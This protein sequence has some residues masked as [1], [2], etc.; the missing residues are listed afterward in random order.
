MTPESIRQE[1]ESIRAIAGDSE[2]AHVAE[3]S[4]RHRVLL[5]IADG[6]ATDPAACAREVLKTTEIK[7]SRWYV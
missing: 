3:D 4:L 7:F 6:T 2:R 1:V 5:A